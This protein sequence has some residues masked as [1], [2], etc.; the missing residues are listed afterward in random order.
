MAAW[1]Q[2][3]N[4]LATT[5]SIANSADDGNFAVVMVP[6]NPGYALSTQTSYLI[7]Y[8]RSSVQGEF[9]A[10]S[11]WLANT[12]TGASTLDA[13]FKTQNSAV[14]FTYLVSPVTAIQYFLAPGGNPLPSSSTGIAATN[15]YMSPGNVFAPIVQFGSGN[16]TGTNA[17]TYTNNLNL[18]VANNSI[19]VIT[20]VGSGG[21]WTYSYGNQTT[22]GQSPTVSASTLQTA[23]NALSTVTPSGVIVTN[24]ATGVWVVQAVDGFAI[25]NPN[26]ANASV[27]GAALTGTG[28]SASIQNVSSAQWMLTISAS[29][30]NYSLQVGSSTEGIY[31]TGNVA[32]NAIASTIQSDLQA[33]LPL[34]LNVTVTGTGPFFITFGGVLANQRFDYNF[35]QVNQGTLSGGTAAL[36]QTAVGGIQGYTG[37]AT[38]QAT[39]TTTVN[40]TCTLTVTA[41]AVDSSGV[42]HT[43]RTFTAT[44]SSVTAGNSVALT[45]GISGD[46]IMRITGIAVAGTATAG[47]FA[48]VSELDR[49]I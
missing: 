4:S 14:P 22:P 47:A 9:A 31:P 39:V 33:T 5:L 16:I 43:G 37:P 7:G 48:L 46:R 13:Y 40:G 24:P 28:H 8:N 34:G 6:P 17:V 45:P 41:N 10:W 27:N 19:Q 30:G 18:P 15:N 20:I 38:T 2:N 35:L 1:N 44:L 23:I 12:G 36:V 25:A 49:I 26:I 21:T 42:F 11:S 3:I 29:S 32:Y